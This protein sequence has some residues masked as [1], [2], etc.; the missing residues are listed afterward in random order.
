MTF[1][2]SAALLRTW[3]IGRNRHESYTVRPL[4][5]ARIAADILK[6]SRVQLPLA[7]RDVRGVL[8]ATREPRGRHMVSFVIRDWLRYFAGT[9]RPIEGQTMERAALAAAWLARAQDA[10]EE[11]GLSYGFMPFRRVAGWQPSYP[12]TT[13]YTIPTFLEFAELSGCDEYRRRA[14]DMAEFET[15]CQ[16]PSGAAYG[17][18]VR[19]LEHAVPVAFNTGMVLQGF[20]AAYQA[21]GKP[22]FATC[23]R[24]AAEFLVNDIGN[25]GYFRSH[26]PFV[27][28]NTIKTYTSL[29]AWPL[30][31][32]GDLLDEDS[33][34]QAALRVGDA[35]LLQQRRRAGW[36]DN[37]C[38]STRTHAPLLHT[39]GYTLQGMLELGIRSERRAYVDAVA[40]A[41]DALLPVCAQGF[42]HGRWYD[43]WQPAAFSSCLT[44]SAQLAVVCYRLADY[45][46]VQKYRDA[47]DRVLD[48][49]KGLQPM[50]GDE[51]IVGGLG[52]SFPLTGAYIRLGFP[53][54]AAKYYLDAL[55]WQY[56]FAQR[57]SARQQALPSKLVARLNDAVLTTGAASNRG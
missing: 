25:D 51:D 40:A 10:T 11:G 27:H 16:M 23:A 50:D 36:F 9:V 48:Y 24:R 56:R 29:C 37:N 6:S 28:E 7:L 46:Q 17:G 1:P 21:S 41:V 39:I 45:T 49:L 12:E 53:G 47:A 54:W 19:A 3:Q 5:V 30:W 44:G 32:A 55:M 35:T 22:L 15:R 31:C 14:L 4:T 8:A 34:R 57:D 2:S 18:T 20:L 42:V 26:G 13:G 38:L 52:G 33:F 43:D